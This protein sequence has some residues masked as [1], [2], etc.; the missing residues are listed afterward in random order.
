MQKRHLLQNYRTIKMNL[1]HDGHSLP[2]E[3]TTDC[4]KEFQKEK[5]KDL[6]AIRDV[7]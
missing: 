7:K 2:L 4:G 3:D 1:S 5:N 6:Y